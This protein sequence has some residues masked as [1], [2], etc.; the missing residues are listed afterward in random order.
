[1]SEFEKRAYIKVINKYGIDRFSK[2]TSGDALNTTVLDKS[3]GTSKTYYGGG[4]SS[5]TGREKKRA[6]GTRGGLDDP[7]SRSINDRTEAVKGIQSKLTEAENSVRRINKILDTNKQV[8]TKGR[9]Y[10][11]KI[12]SS[13]NKAKQ[14]KP[15]K[16]RVNNS[17]LDKY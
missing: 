16:I 2:A 13:F 12:M 14:T 4:V 17:L 1:M 5:E 11:K 8:R 9:E 3:T 7:I 10:A 15:T 6:I